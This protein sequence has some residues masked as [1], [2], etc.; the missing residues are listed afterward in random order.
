MILC[1]EKLR[2]TRWVLVVHATKRSIYRDNHDVPDDVDGLC[3]AESMLVVGEF[4]TVI[5][6]HWSGR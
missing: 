3:A 2:V 4:F 1:S 5:T 6:S